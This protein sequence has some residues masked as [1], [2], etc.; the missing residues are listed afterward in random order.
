M[1]PQTAEDNMDWML[2]GIK[3]DVQ[4]LKFNLRTGDPDTY[5]MSAIT[6]LCIVSLVGQLAGWF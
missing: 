6:I 3:E 4:E 2:K 1:D 5:L